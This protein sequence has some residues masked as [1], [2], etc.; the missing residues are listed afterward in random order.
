MAASRLSTWTADAN[1]PRCELCRAEFTWLLSRR[2]HCRKCGRCVCAECSPPVCMR[3]LPQK[4][5][6]DPCRQCKLCV[7]PPSRQMVGLGSTPTHMSGV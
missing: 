4:G 3:P 1:A 2:H 6:F 5:Y 7:P